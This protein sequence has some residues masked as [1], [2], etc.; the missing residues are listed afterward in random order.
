MRIM[1]R[2]VG[3][4]LLVGFGCAADL[5]AQSAQVSGRVADASESRV[6]GATVTALN[7][8]TGLRRASTS[9][10]EGYYAIPALPPGP[11]RLTAELSGFATSIRRGLV[12]VADQ[13]VRVDFVLGVGGVADEVT[14]TAD[15]LLES[16][17]ATVGTIVT[18]RS[19]RE[20]PLDVR[21]PMGL[22]VLTPGVVTGGLFGNTGSLDVGRGFFK[23]DFK[24]GGGRPDSQDILLDGASNITG[25]RTFLAYIPSV[26]ATQ[27][28]KVETNAFSAEYGRTTGGVVTI[29]TRAGSNKLTGTAYE[30]LRDSALDANGFFANRAGLPKVYFRR[31]QFGAVVGGPIRRDRT[32]FFAAHEGL[33]QNYPQTLIS[34]VPTERQ[35]LGD[36]SQ[37]FDNQG[38]LVVIYDPRT[39]TRLPSGQIVRQPFP[40][41]V[42]PA[43]RI[44]PVARAVLGYYPAPNRPGAATTGADNFVHTGVQQQ[45]TNNYSARIDHTIGSSR[46]FGRY[47]YQR[48]ES[49]APVRWDGPGARD[50]RTI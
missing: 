16:Q 3:L 39:T 24:V 6:P 14:V 25:D 34:T 1:L 2:G 7:E 28:F 37:T 33:R 13:S 44:D 20:L 8:A 50:A 49:H 40:G 22:V 19:I 48:S 26:D 46:L 30:F 27:E 36:F 42:I 17:S 41:N 5:L 9:N 45:N 43:D 18:E 10:G 38:R 21:E 23:A 32:F 35:R 15:A 29:V 31:N 11:Y 12:L 4:V 47:S